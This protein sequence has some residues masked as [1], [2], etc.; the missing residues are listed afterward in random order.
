MAWS[1]AI[2]RSSRRMSSPSGRAARSRSARRTGPVLPRIERLA[3]EKDALQ[4]GAGA[5]GGIAEVR[6]APG[7]D[8][9]VARGHACWM[10]RLGGARRP[11][12]A[13]R[14]R[15]ASFVRGEPAKV[16]GSRFRLADLAG[17]VAITD[18]LAGLAL[19]G[20]EL[21]VDLG[22]DVVD[23]AEFASAARG[24]ARLRGGGCAGR[25]CRRPPRGE[26]GVLR[27]GGDQFADLALADDR[28]RMRPGRGVGE[29]ELH[30]AGAHV[31]AVDPVDRARLALDAAADLDLLGIVEG[32]R[33]ACGRYCRR[34]AKPRPCSAPGGCR[35]PRRSRRPCRMRACS[36]RNSRPSPSAAPRP[37]WI[38]RSRS[39]RP[40]RSARA[41]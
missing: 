9:L 24:G 16:Q 18:R 8:R 26:C 29:E 31:A 1:S 2:M 38:C 33:G 28:R 15:R 11:R 32:D 40:R 30:V 6:Q 20:F 21:R 7:R 41:R 5:G 25:K 23:A 27:L 37:G 14:R 36:C 12:R 10:A 34:P 17:K 39:G 35:F 19:Q 4:G 13:R 22:D 3:G